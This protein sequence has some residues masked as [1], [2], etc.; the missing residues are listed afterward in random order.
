MIQRVCACDKF[1]KLNQD[2]ID[3]QKEI[4]KVSGTANMLILKNAGTHIVDLKK[5]KKDITGQYK[6]AT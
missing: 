5:M 1:I 2:D 3:R 4:A 6:S